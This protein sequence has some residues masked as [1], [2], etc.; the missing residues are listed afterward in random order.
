L[1][2]QIKKQQTRFYG[3]AYQVKQIFM[4][5]QKKQDCWKDELLQRI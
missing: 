1:R 4:A 2:V 5:R 3:A